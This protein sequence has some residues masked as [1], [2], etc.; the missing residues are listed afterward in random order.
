VIATGIERSLV[1]LVSLARRPPGATPRS[2]STSP[3]RP[4]REPKPEHATS[5]SS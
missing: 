5:T 1:D 3:R 4:R 2:R